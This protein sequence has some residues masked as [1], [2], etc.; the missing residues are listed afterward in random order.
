MDKMVKINSKLLL[1][2][3]CGLLITGC[4]YIQST[5]KHFD[6]QERFKDTKEKSILKHIL[7]RDT[8]FIYGELL[9]E[10]GEYKD[11]SIAV[12]AVSETDLDHEVVD[13]FHY[14]KSASYYGLHLPD[15]KYKLLVLADLNGDGLYQSSEIISWLPADFNRKSY[16]EL[17]AGSIDIRIADQVLPDDYKKLNIPVL[18]DSDDKNQ[19]ILYPGGTLRTLD[20]PIFST[21]I[22]TMGMY[23]PAAFLETAPLMFYA[24]EDD[25]FHKIPVVFVHGIGGSITDFSTILENLDRTRYKPWFFYYPSGSDLDKLGEL[26]YRIFLSGKLIPL[27]DTP[28]VVVAHSMGGLVV[29]KALTSYSGSEEENKLELYVSIATPYGG[30]PSA[31]LGVEKAP[32]VIPSWRDLNPDGDFIGKLFET[33]FPE[34]MEHHL[35][36]AFGNTSSF[37]VGENSDGA[38]PLSSQ[39]YKPAQA[40][41]TRQYGYNQGHTSILSDKTMMNQL[42]ELIYRIKF[43]LPETHMKVLT[44][45]GFNVELS[46]NYSRYEQYVIEHQGKYMRALSTGL[47]QPQNDFESHFVAVSNGQVAATNPYESAWLKF[48]ADYPKIAAG[49][50]GY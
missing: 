28:I 31:K 26:F 20:D 42:F 13:I 12:A 47:I 24:L 36:Y 48:S 4:T 34:S 23:D 45:G 3:I 32:L 39:L 43:P 1:A 16:P 5:L 49:K 27:G 10:E 15:G 25:L 46:S 11:Y 14:G 35:F 38:V 33:P 37:K 8:F 9:D 30:V 21:D 22:V 50:K 41:A 44:A 40:Q 17:V 2:C 7:T 19:S 29:R 6:Y 18:A